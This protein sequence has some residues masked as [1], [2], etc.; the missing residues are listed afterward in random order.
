MRFQYF[1]ESL[2]DNWLRLWGVV[3][4]TGNVFINNHNLKKVGWGG[5]SGD[6][7]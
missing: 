7:D 4:L 6:E 2:L 5:R 1:L 3:S